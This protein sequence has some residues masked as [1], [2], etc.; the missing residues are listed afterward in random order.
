[1]GKKRYW[2]FAGGHYYPSGGMGDKRLES[3]D[4]EE[5]RAEATKPDKYNQRRFNYDWWHILDTESLE[6]IDGDTNE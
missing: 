4:I 3:D 5:C 6:I 1:M 2:L